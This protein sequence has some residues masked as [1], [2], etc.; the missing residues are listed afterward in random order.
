MPFTFSSKA[1]PAFFLN[2]GGRAQRR[3]QTEPFSRGLRPDVGSLEA[4]LAA[5]DDRRIDV[6]LGRDWLGTV[7]VADKLPFFATTPYDT[8]HFAQELER[9]GFVDRAG[10]LRRSLETQSPTSFCRQLRAETGLD[11]N[12]LLSL[13]ENLSQWS[14][15]EMFDQGKT[16]NTVVLERPLSTADERAL[17]ILKTTRPSGSGKA[18]MLRCA[19]EPPQRSVHVPLPSRIQKAFPELERA[20]ASIRQPLSGLTRTWQLVWAHRGQ[21]VRL[22]HSSECATDLKPAFIEESSSLGLQ[23]K[24][25]LAAGVAV[26]E[27]VRGQ[28]RLVV[29]VPQDPSLLLALEGTTNDAFAVLERSLH[30]LAPAPPDPSYLTLPML[31]LWRAVLKLTFSSQEGPKA[32]ATDLQFAS[33]GPALANPSRH[34]ARPL[35]YRLL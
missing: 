10:P 34:V 35:A 11:R 15:R 23:L 9:A 33:T 25:S 1:Q 19:V 21:L 7:L 14:L 4:R 27:S 16:D 24:E 18:W 17:Y 32:K 26:E 29:P 6:F 22:A 30:L 28:N 3:T 8:R 13:I 12:A 2:G 20:V 31:A 5:G